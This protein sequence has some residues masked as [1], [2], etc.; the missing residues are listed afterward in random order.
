MILGERLKKLRCENGI[1]QEEFA[2]II[3][4]SRSSVAGYEV[5]DRMPDSN[6]LVYIA[7]YFNCTLDYLFGRSD[8]KNEIE[9]GLVD[10]L[11]EKLG[12]SVESVNHI[13]PLFNKYLTIIKVSIYPNSNELTK[14]LENTIEWLYDYVLQSLEDVDLQNKLTNAIAS[15]DKNLIELYDNEKNSGHDKSYYFRRF[16]ISLNNYI[17]VLQNEHNKLLETDEK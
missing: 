15:N 4:K 1:S 12:V 6:T 13:M 5:G 7:D 8:Y 17:N 9:K 14:E 11:S 2:K 10:I 16:S 3:G